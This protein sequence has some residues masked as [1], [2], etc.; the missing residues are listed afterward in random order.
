VR[1]SDKERDREREGERERGREGERERERERERD[2]C[3]I[4]IFKRNDGCLGTF[5]LSSI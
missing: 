2:G 4:L 1:K 5:K 3:F